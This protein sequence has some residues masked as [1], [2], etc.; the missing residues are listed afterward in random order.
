MVCKRRET[1]I[2]YFKLIAVVQEK[3]SKLNKKSDRKE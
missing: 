2:I 3:G 1:D